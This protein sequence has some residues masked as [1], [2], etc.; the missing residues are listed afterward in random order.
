MSAGCISIAF[1]PMTPEAYTKTYAFPEIAE[2]NLLDYSFPVTGNIAMEG[3]LIYRPDPKSYYPTIREP[4]G[5]VPSHD[6]E[7]IITGKISYRES[8]TNMA[9]IVIPGRNTGGLPEIH[10]TPY[11]YRSVWNGEIVFDT[12][13]QKAKLDLYVHAADTKGEYKMAV[14]KKAQTQDAHI[15]YAYYIT[16]AE[17]VPQ[18]PPYRWA[19][20]F[21][22]DDTA[23]ALYAVREEN[24]Y[25]KYPDYTEADRKKSKLSYIDAAP[26]ADSL[27]EFF[28]KPEQKFQLLDKTGVVAAEIMGNRY[29]IYDTVPE[30]EWDA[31]RQ[32]IG[33]FYVFRLI[34]RKIF[35]SYDFGVS[36]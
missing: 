9:F 14:L 21:T 27:S 15:D 20:F 24:Y 11:Q 25:I 16:A 8:S 22:R 13:T 7:I 18:K 33:L 2:Q 35:T 3:Y 1:S 30:S 17:A 36:F 23:Y 26:W 19:D 34:A 32:N 4:E 12:M 28:L 5:F 10:W 31:M 6:A 29:V